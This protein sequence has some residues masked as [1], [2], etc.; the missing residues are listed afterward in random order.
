MTAAIWFGLAAIALV[1]AIVLLYFD[2]VQ[3]Q[4]TGHVRQVWAKSQGYTY[5][6]V[7]PSLAANWHRGPM[8]KLGYLSA[9]DVVSGNRKG[10]KFVLF[11][12]EDSAT[13]VA[14]R[15]QIGSD[16]DIDLRSKTAAPPKDHD[17]ELLGAIGD[18]VVFATN[19]DVARHAVDQRMVAFIESL[20]DSVQQLWSEG[21]WTLGMLP[22]GSG[23]R[24]W[25]T[26]I[27]AVLRLSGLLHVLPPVVDRG[28]SPDD[29][30]YESDSDDRDDFERDEFE[31][32]DEYDR[33]DYAPDRR[34][35][36]RRES[37]RYDTDA[38]FDRDEFDRA[39]FDDRDDAERAARFDRDGDYAP[40]LEDIAGESE[41]RPSR[42]PALAIVP[43]PRDRVRRAWSD[44]DR[45]EEAEP[46]R[47]VDEDDPADRPGGPFH[48]GFRPYQGPAPR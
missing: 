20:P 37:G 42:R 17:L 25:E 31:S 22:V 16:I 43:D 12:L 5:V 40:L 14:V 19:P 45:P 4:R 6:S 44:E 1:G 30:D 47:S 29:E 7:E 38:E 10:E 36:G 11:D 3:R 13:M 27:D 39:D 34:E 28:H 48:P 23:P 8:T 24:D 32:D 21:N 41:A 18:R 2:R 35:R 9:V 26:A 15:R 33:D 46:A